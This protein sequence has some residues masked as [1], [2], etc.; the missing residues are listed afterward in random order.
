MGIFFRQPGSILEFPMSDMA[1]AVGLRLRLSSSPSRGEGFRVSCTYYAL[2]PV[3]V[4][5]GWPVASS[6]PSR[7]SPNVTY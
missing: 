3:H 6:S 5:T 2:C 1:D 4:E 7:N